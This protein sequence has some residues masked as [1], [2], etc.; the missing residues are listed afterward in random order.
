MDLE[1]SHLVAEILR[2]G[3]MLDKQQ[4]SLT[5]HQHYEVM[6]H[7]ALKILTD[8]TRPPVSITSSVTCASIDSVHYANEFRAN[9]VIGHALEDFWP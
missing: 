6:T 3:G 9:L 4:S 5:E 8:L 1:V 7:V 2:F